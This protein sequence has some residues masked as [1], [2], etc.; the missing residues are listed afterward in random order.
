MVCFCILFVI[1]PQWKLYS[2][3][4]NPINE[5]TGING[6]R[7]M[8]WWLFSASA[9]LSMMDGAKPQFWGADSSIHR[10]N[11]E[12]PISE[13]SID[14]IYSNFYSL[15]PADIE[16]QKHTLFARPYVSRRNNPAKF[17]HV[18]HLLWKPG[19][20]G[21]FDSIVSK[22]QFRFGKNRPCKWETLHCPS[23][24]PIC[25]PMPDI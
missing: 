14:Q 2:G 16:P 1:T 13:N 22:F 8:G 21:R 19:C 18:L 5:L 12:G 25:F 10:A 24:W 6:S 4:G 20:R 7:Y 3:H 17:H 11:D 15:L 9:Q 23:D